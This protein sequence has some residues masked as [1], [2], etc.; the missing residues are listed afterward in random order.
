[1]ELSFLFYLFIY[2]SFDYVLLRLLNLLIYHQHNKPFEKRFQYF[3]ITSNI[4]ILVWGTFKFFE[5][6]LVIELVYGHIFLFLILLFIFLLLLFVIP[7][8][9]NPWWGTSKSKILMNSKI[10][11]CRCYIWSSKRW[12]QIYM[13]VFTYF[14]F[15]SFPNHFIPPLLQA[16]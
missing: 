16:I 2:C 15:I 14:P 8:L 3:S 5:L 9:P 1:M 7:L 12:A 11:I 6:F 13:F 10:K 4:P